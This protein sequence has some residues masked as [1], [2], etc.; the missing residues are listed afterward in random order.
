MASSLTVSSNPIAPAIE[1][2][3]LL[4]FDNAK[5]LEGYGANEHIRTEKPIV[6]VIGS[7]PG[8]G[9]LAT[10]LVPGASA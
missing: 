6:V 8:N 10:C 1:R 3:R 4:G 9:K 2:K 7:G 5:D